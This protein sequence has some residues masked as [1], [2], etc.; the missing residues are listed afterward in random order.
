MFLSLLAKKYGSY[1]NMSFN[2]A[3]VLIGGL[4][5]STEVTQWAVIWSVHFLNM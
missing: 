2:D 1:N 3:C 4:N 5:I